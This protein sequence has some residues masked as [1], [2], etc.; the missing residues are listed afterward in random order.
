MLLGF[1]KNMLFVG[2]ALIESLVFM[3][4]FNA[5]AP[6]LINLGLPLPIDNVRWGFMWALFIL[7]GFTG[8]WIKKLSPFSINVNNSN[9]VEKSKKDSE[10]KIT[11]RKTFKEKLE[12]S[13]KERNE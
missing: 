7:I 1:I 8:R 12:E 9:K 11:T 2:F 13:V 3:I 5:I 10:S 6:T 4:A